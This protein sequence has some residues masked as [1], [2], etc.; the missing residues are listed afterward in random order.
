MAVPIVMELTHYI[1]VRRTSA[2]VSTFVNAVSFTS[3]SSPAPGWWHRILI[4]MER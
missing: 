1:G 3:T 4:S 2:C